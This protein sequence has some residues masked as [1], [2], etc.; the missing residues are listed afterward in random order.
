MAKHA[1]KEWFHKKA[2]GEISKEYNID[3]KKK[4]K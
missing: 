3:L 1:A 2:V 4:I